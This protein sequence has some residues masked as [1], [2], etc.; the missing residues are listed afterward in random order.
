[1]ELLLFI[2]LLVITL[3]CI[4]NLANKLGKDFNNFLEEKFPNIK[5]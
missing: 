2:I 3:I 5:E 1:M 4:A